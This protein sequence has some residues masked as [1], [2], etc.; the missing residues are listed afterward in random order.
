MD[1][2]I[3]VWVVLIW[4]YLIFSVKPKLDKIITMLETLETEDDKETV[5]DTSKI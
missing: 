4:F 2:A 1:S 3:T 5:V